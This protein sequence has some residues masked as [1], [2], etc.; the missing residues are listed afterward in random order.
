MPTTEYRQVATRAKVI[1]DN[2]NSWEDFA[3]ADINVETAYR[4]P[5][6]SGPDETAIDHWSYRGQAAM[7]KLGNGNIVRV[8]IGDGSTAD[9]NIYIQTISA[10]DDPEAWTNW[11]L[12]YASDNYS[13]AIEADPADPDNFFVYT[14]RS[15]GFFINN[16]LKD[17]SL[18]ALG[19]VKIKPVAF[20]PTPGFLYIQTTTTDDDGA[21]V[22]TWRYTTNA[23]GIPSI[24]WQGDVANYR[25]YRHDMVAMKGDADNWH[26]FRSY[27]LEGG[28]RNQTASEILTCDTIQT[29][30]PTVEEEYNIWDNVRYL[31]GPSGQAGF[32]TITNLYITKLPDSEG[33]LDYFLFYNERQRDILGNT[34]SNLKMPLFWQRS[35]D[36]PYY[37]SAPTPVGYSIWGFAGAVAVGDY[38]YVAGNGRV[39]RRYWPTTEIPIEDFIIEGNYNK[40]RSNEKSTGKLICANPN[41]ALGAQLGLTSDNPAG[42]T[43]R[44]LWIELGKKLSTDTDPE[45]KRDSDWWIANLQ[46][47]K[48]DDKQHLEINFADFWHRL[49]TPFLDT[50]SLP[51][52]FEWTDWGEDGVN[53]LYNWYNDTDELFRYSPV[54]TDDYLWTIPRLR[55]TISGDG[56]GGGGTITLLQN[57]RG[58]NGFAQVSLWQLNTGV[59]FRYQD[60]NNYMYVL[61]TPTRIE[62]HQV[63]AGVDSLANNS[64][65]SG[66]FT[67]AFT[68]KVSFYFHYVVVDYNIGSTIVEW[69]IGNPP[70]LTGFVGVMAKGGAGL[71]TLEASGVKIH[72]FNVAMTTKELCKVLFAYANE[73]SAEIELEADETEMV[74]LI[75]GPQSDLDNPAK[76]LTQLLDAT[77]IEAKW[78]PD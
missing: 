11:S 7:C 24:Q 60:A 26:R 40:P 39:L 47:V 64:Y 18:I 23:F 27:A 78:I 8:R 71:T 34:L 75:W 62:L 25:W 21:R 28:Q 13:I 53:Q 9:K 51:G 37:L 67:A 15:G 38:I 48:T 1:D 70:V 55:T 42:L 19:I 6:G 57:W 46:K 58:E 65:V 33:N 77:K 68:L 16:V 56:P 54:V 74:A 14:S 31:K 59:V 2:M 63:V 49:E 76:A 69:F 4:Y 29:A 66:T 44:R 35:V 36:V 17:S 12:L 20:N 52:R 41:N 50:I 22:L 61:V 43:E 10:P 45:W 3:G 73:H 32:Q 30:F 5:L 72:D